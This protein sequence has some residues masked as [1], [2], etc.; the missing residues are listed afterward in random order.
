MNYKE[1]ALALQAPFPNGTVQLS[2][3][4]KRQAHIPVQV[5]INRLEK[6]AG[7]H[8]SWSVIGEPTIVEA[9][10]AVIVRGELSILGAKRSGMGFSH[11]DRGK[12]IK[13]VSAFRNAVNAAE[14]DAIRSACDK[15]LIGWS[16]LAPY[17]DCET[18]ESIEINNR[19]EDIRETD[20]ER[21]CQR[22]A[23]KLTDIDQLFLE[24]NRIKS[25]YCTEHV[26]KHLIKKI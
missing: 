1:I 14:S 23:K 3:S 15:F 9:D 12:D 10:S 5:Y 2:S 22:C 19:S 4:N 24:V 7:E 21:V 25:P 20:V 13:N 26:P 11:Y 16:D 8:W 6:E 17:R 18:D